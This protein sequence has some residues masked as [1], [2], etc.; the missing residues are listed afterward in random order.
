MKRE[1]LCVGEPM[2][3]SCE[4]GRLWCRANSLLIKADSSDCLPVRLAIGEPEKIPNNMKIFII[5]T[6]RQI[7]N[8][9]QLLN[10]GM[11]DKKI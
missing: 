10:T 11:E 9:I 6:I 5:V 8:C 3:T 2:S 7:L 4:A 1:R